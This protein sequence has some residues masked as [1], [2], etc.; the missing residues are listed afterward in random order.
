[1]NI[2]KFF[3]KDRIC[4]HKNALLN[5]NEGYCPDCGAYLKKTF[6]VV[7]CKHCDIKRVGV[8]NFGD[9]EP[10]TRYCENC[11]GHE[12][13]VEKLERINFFDIKYVI[14]KL[15]EIFVPKKNQDF[16]EIWT[17]NVQDDEFG[18]YLVKKV[19]P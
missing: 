8:V 11:G 1:M 5:S 17:E 15:E 14:F 13:Y 9:I 3:L 18:G 7:R 16:T 19:A 10:L 6:Y 4:L 2:L 12:Y